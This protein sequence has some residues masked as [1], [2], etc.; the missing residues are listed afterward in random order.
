MGLSDRP[1]QI[2][3]ITGYFDSG[4]ADLGEIFATRGYAVVFPNQDLDVKVSGWHG[5][6]LLKRY[7]N[8]EVLRYNDIMLADAGMK[9]HQLNDNPVSNLLDVKPFI[10]MFQQRDIV[11]VDPRFVYTWPAWGSY[12]THWVGCR[13]DPKP[14]AARLAQ[15]YLDRNVEHWLQQHAVYSRRLDSLPG[16][17]CPVAYA[18]LVDEPHRVYLRLRKHGLAI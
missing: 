15:Q 9:W 13:R 5:R 4:L 7:E 8:I 17:V 1:R 6:D 14:I 18:D 16:D 11:L 10:A 12:V 2:V 3:G